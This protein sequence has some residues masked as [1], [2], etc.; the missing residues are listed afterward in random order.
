MVPTKV[1]NVPSLEVF[2]ARMDGTLSQWKESLPIA[3]GTGT[4]QRFRSLLSK[5]F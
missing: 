3:G 1:V 5:Q 2:K 4:R